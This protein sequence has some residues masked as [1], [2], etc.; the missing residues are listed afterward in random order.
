MQSHSMNRRGV[1]GHAGRV[2]RVGSLLAALS[3]A[4]CAGGPEEGVA[5]DDETVSVQQALDYPMCPPSCPIPNVL[6]AFGPACN[7]LPTFM[8][9]SFLQNLSR[10]PGTWAAQSS[11]AFGGVALRAIDGN[12]DGNFWNNSV[13]HTNNVGPVQVGPPGAT[14]SQQWL[15]I[16]LGAIRGVR[17]VRIYNR[18]DC[19]AE[20]LGSITV[21]GINPGGS[22]WMN[23]G[24]ANMN[25]NPVIEIDLLDVN[26]QTFWIQKND[27]D[28][29][30]LAEVQVWGVVL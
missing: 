8:P 28:Y 27:S 6:R 30:S 17:H 20:R 12:T 24:G 23:L 1:G 19:C 22:G 18:T 29:L 14:S 11:T 5:G 3:A 10:K 15:T 2:L 26:T 16:D 13:T 25:S 7:C 9:T 21:W 4:G